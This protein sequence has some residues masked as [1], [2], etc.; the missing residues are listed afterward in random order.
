M[1]SE[2]TKNMEILL[3]K[4]LNEVEKTNLQNRSPYYKE[5]HP[6]FFVFYMKGAYV[7]DP[8]FGTNKW[9]FV[10]LNNKDL[11]YDFPYEFHSFTLHT[12]QRT[13]K[14]ALRFVINGKVFPDKQIIA[15]NENDFKD[16]V[17]FVGH[18]YDYQRCYQFSNQESYQSG[19]GRAEYP[20]KMIVPKNW[21]LNFEFFM[22]STS[23]YWHT[24]EI[25]GWKLHYKN[26]D[27][28][29]ELEGSVK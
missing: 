13:Y 27:F 11:L 2:H 8:N 23:V 5:W 24:L 29:K 28:I 21:T 14:P 7:I 9:G 25:H 18:N 12:E 6:L 17:E 10:K 15:S 22:T 26:V 1:S 4:I 16:W 20:F 3:Q 19:Y